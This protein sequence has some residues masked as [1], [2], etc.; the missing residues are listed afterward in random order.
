M[1]DSK[2]SCM[3]SPRIWLIKPQIGDGNIV[4]QYRA[5]VKRETG[6]ANQFVFFACFLH[7]GLFAYAR[8]RLTVGY[9]RSEP[10][11]FFACF[12]HGGMLR[13]PVIG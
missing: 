10:V 5:S 9:K 1:N 4:W 3:V 7:G 6:E 2:L 12:L 13:T 11:R 8:Y